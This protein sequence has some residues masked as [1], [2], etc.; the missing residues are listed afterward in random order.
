MIGFDQAYRLVLDHVDPLGA[1]KVSLI[2]STGRAAA[3]R[4]TA[5]VWS[6]TADSSLKDGYAVRSDD[7]REAAPGH[8]VRLEVVGSAAAGGGWKGMLQAG[9]AVRIL[10]GAP[11]PAGAQAVL[12]EEFTRREGEDA[13]MAFNTAEPGRN[14]LERGAD[15]RRGQ[16]LVKAGERLRPTVVGYL[17]SAGYSQIPVVKTP[18]VGVIATGDEVVAPGRH[19]RQGQLYA[20]NLVILTSWCRRFRFAVDT[21]VLPDQRED[22]KAGLQRAL[23]D[24]DAVLTSGGAWKG[25]RDL[26]AEVLQELGWGK[27]FHRVRMGPGKAVGFGLVGKKPVFLL[28]GGPPSNHM[29][30]LQLALPGLMRLAGWGNPGLHTVPVTLGEAICGQADWTQFVHGVLS[31]GESN[32]EFRPLDLPSRLQMLAGSEAVVR[33]PEGI[34]RIGEG[35]IVPGQILR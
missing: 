32:L 4:L 29:A 16:E 6:P 2:D 9:Q 23:H 5:R 7:V 1:E 12:A 28:P 10:T 3:E 26:V 34:E 18:R 20:S 11:I 13:V 24:F 8:E 30:F 17:A 21:K 31:K 33:I 25:D 22:L 35:E 19:L 27:I 15:V 14:V